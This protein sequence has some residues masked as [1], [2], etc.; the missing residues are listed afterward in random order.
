[1]EALADIAAAR[2]KTPAQA[3]LA[4]I[5]ANP[6]GIIPI[7]GTT[8]LAQLEDNL[9]AVGWSL[10][11]AEYAWLNQVSDPGTPYSL[12]FFQQYGIPWR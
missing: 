1:M 4:W 6:N 11:A 3:A 9:G 12:D 2:G 10:S 5:L 7:I 8:N